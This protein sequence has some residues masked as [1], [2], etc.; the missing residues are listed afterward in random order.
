MKKLKIA[1]SLLLAVVMLLA[2]TACGEKEEPSIAGYYILESGTVNGQAL[3]EEELVWQAYDLFVLLKEDATAVLF[4]GTAVLDATYQNGELNL[5]DAGTMHYAVSGTKLTLTTS[6]GELIFRLV[7]EAAPDIEQIKTALEESKKIDLTGYYVLASYTENGETYGAEGFEDMYFLANADGTGILSVF[8][9]QQKMYWNQTDIWPE[10]EPDDK[11]A[12]I[13][14]GDVLTLCAE[15]NTQI[16]F[17]RSDETP[18]DPNE[19]TESTIPAQ[20]Y[21]LYAYDMGDGYTE[22]A[23]IFLTINDDG[24]GV[25]EYEGGAQDIIWNAQTVQVA[26]VNY[27]YELDEEGNLILSGSDGIFYFTAIS[28][29][30][31][32]W[33]KEWYGFWIMDDCTGDYEGYE[34]NWWDLCARSTDN[35]D[36]GYMLLWDED[37]NSA[38]DPI[39]E[40]YF[41]VIDGIFCSDGGWFYMADITD[42]LECD[43]TYSPS[44]DMLVLEG[45]YEGDDGSYTYAI[46]LRPWGTYWDDLDESYWPYYYETWYL[47][48]IEKG[49]S[50]P[51]VFELPKG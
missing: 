7:N 11:A 36:G 9:A 26:S 27:S 41:N 14:Q 40:F 48:L 23:G 28:D 31:G 17:V 49:E 21:G 24:T 47:P 2:L 30:V 45:R 44:E 34:G 6:D 16:V 13:L 25:Y 43:F 51:D 22:S 4:N 50:L 39:G 15:E 37:Y 18:P 46:Y 35:A 8:G 3:T 29:E 12:Y 19:T 5:T 33:S 42:E 32:T 20:K 10:S 1:I 38:D